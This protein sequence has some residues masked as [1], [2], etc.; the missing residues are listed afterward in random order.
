VCRER[1]ELDLSKYEFDLI[2]DEIKEAL[3]GRKADARELVSK[4]SHPEEEVIKVIRWLLDHNKLIMDDQHL[5]SWREPDLFS[6]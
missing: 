2:L 1:N 6:R 5:L 4:V 3:T